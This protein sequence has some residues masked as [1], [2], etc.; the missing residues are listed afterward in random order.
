[1]LPDGRGRQNGIVPLWG[2]MH[3][4]AKL[5]LSPSQKKAK[6]NERKPAML[7]LC[8]SRGERVRFKAKGKWLNASDESSEFM[9]PTNRW[10]HSSDLTCPFNR[11]SV[12]KNRAAAETGKPGACEPTVVGKDDNKPKTETSIPAKTDEARKGA[13]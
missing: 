11:E 4:A 5:R 9:I 6:T 2:D 7:I 10:D 3:V 12:V 1:M 13:D 8:P